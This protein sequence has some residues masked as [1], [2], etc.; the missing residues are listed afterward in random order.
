MAP[1]DSS[2]NLGN[3][4][5]FSKN[6]KLSN[7]STSIRMS[8]LSRA[9]II[10][11]KKLKVG[12]TISLFCSKTNR[13]CWR[14]N[15]YRCSLS[16]SLSCIKK[17]SCLNSRV[18]SIRTKKAEMKQEK[19]KI[20]RAAFWRLKMFQGDWK[21]CSRDMFGSMWTSLTTLLRMLLKK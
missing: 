16:R 3:T 13:N 7:K 6:T 14:R 1:Q 10:L 8:E 5:V 20:D 4:L 15:S 21:A 12:L 9:L 11:W 19:S 2:T 17:A 18:K